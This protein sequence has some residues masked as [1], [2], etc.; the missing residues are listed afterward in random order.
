MFAAKIE[1]FSHFSFPLLTTTLSIHSGGFLSFFLVFWVNQSHSRY[2]SLYDQSMKCKGIIFHAATMAATCLPYAQ[3]SR[4]VR[5]L[6]VAHVAGYVGL[7][8]VYSSE[9]YFN[10]VNRTQALLTEQERARLD[11]I[12]LDLGGNCSREVTVWCMNEV[13]TARV[14]TMTYPEERCSKDNDLILVL[15][16][17]L[18]IWFDN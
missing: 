8:P 10:H 3:A 2:F 12:N 13:E 9:S 5:Y 7:S 1:S 6:N 14:S 18:E 4:L 16:L 17:L 11:E 15:I